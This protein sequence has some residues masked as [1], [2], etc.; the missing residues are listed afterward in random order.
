MHPGNLGTA[1]PERHRAL[2]LSDLH[3]GTLGSRPDLICDFLQSATAETIYLVGDIFDV[4]EPLIVRW[5]DSE[6]RVVDLLRQRAAEGSRL[7]YLRGNHDAAYMTG[8]CTSPLGPEIA[9]PV[10][11]AAQ[12]VHSLQDGQRLLVIHGDVCDARPLRLHILTRIGSR[13]DSMLLLVDGALRKLRIAFGPHGR[14]PLKLILAAVNDLLYRSRSHERRLVALSRAE[15][16]DGVICGHFHIATLHHEHGPLYVNCGDWV[17][18]FTAVVETQDGRLQLLG[19]AVAEGM[20]L[21]V[22]VQASV[23][24]AA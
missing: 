14:G 10:E 5:G 20:A 22:H 24:V 23:G 18:S 7:V 21:P 4:W 1:Q 16:L 13:I 9:L 17:D 11:P 12:V 19:A 8:C 2:F 15:G 6:Q 3:L